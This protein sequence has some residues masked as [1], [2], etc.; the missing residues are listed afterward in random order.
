MI[1]ARKILDQLLGA[2]GP[3]SGGG[4]VQH[5][6]PATAP[7]GTRSAGSGDIL[8]Q[9][10]DLA[11]GNLGGLA[12]GAIAG[13]LASILLGGGKGPKISGSAVK[14]GGLAVLGGLAYKAWQN[15]QEKQA[16]PQAPSPQ[17]GPV[18]IAPPPAQ[19]PFTPSGP[20]DEQQLGL[21][22]VRAMIAAARADGRIDGEEIA[23]IREGLKASGAGADEQTFLLEQL[24]KPD[25]LDGLAA[26]A[27]GPELASEV[28]LAARLTVDA[29][30]QAERDFL[31][32]FG[33]K[34][35]LDPA[36]IAHLEATA[37][38]AKQSGVAAA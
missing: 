17:S 15:Y 11:R 37:A 19:T 3:L 28:W 30:S 16:A 12:G 25:D 13:S 5:R 7:Q 14:L 20:S 21:L 31:A 35:G 32:S 22:L 6:P 2:G 1:D 26:E 33:S 4:G 29:D 9:V 18:P 23:K 34:L 27:R 36:L 10:Q 24:G 8:S 38:Q